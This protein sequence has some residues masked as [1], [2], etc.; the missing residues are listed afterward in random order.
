MQN[1]CGALMGRASF[2][3]LG[4][5]MFAGNF[6]TVQAQGTPPQAQGTQAQ[7]ATSQKKWKSDEEYNMF[8][9]VTKDL[10]DKNP[11]KALTDLDA[12]KQKFPESDYKD[13]RELMY[14]QAYSDSGQPAKAIDAATPLVSQ[15]LDKVF[16]DPKT[17]TAQVIR[18]LYTVSTSITQVPNPTP[19]ELATADK[20]AHE[21]ASFDTKPEGV[22]DASW[23][24]ARKQL[25]GFGKAALLNMAARPGLEKMKAKDCA[26]A[27]AEFRKGVE[28][29]PNSS[30]LAYQLGAALLCQQHDKPE[31]IPAAIYEFERAAALDP[32]LDGT[33]KD[34]AAVVKYADNAYIKLHGSD[35][36]LAQLKDQA[37]QGPLPP[38]GFKIETATEIATKKQA[39]FEQSNPQ[40]ALWMKLKG[41]LSDTNG[42]QYFQSQLKDAAVPQL[43]GTLVEAKPACHPKELLVAVPL[44][45]TQGALR[46]EITLKLDAPLGGKPEL[47]TEFHWEGVPTA[48]TRDPFM[49]TMTVEKSKVQGLKETPCSAAPA[50]RPV[51]HKK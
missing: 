47:N 34:P 24:D 15:G 40:L 10:T 35:E 1:R 4:I 42:D 2:A 7:G 14:M 50:R 17:G 11:T 45:D 22:P 12:W 9:Q 13:D 44:P 27:E 19:E 26:G 48:F 43:R 36:G 8:N 38:E 37:K 6:V 3:A 28:Q 20:A 33:S 49:L 41:A 51:T 30:Y 31:K 21:L 32:T 18:V 16:N 46:P 23:P 5:A 39:Q 25:Q 29:M